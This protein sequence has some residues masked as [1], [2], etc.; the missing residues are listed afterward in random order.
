MLFLMSTQ[1][2]KLVS[3]ALQFTYQNLKSCKTHEKTKQQ[4]AKPI[5][6]KLKTKG[7]VFFVSVFHVIR[8]ISNSNM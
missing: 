1:Y 3:N 8:K 5:G 2:K 7:L 4:I 6:E